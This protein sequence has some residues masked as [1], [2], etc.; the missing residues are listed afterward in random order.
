MASST[1]SSST[2]WW[3]SLGTDAKVGVGFGT[4]LILGLLGYAI[5]YW[6]TNHKSSS[7]SSMLMTPTQTTAAI[8]P[9]SGSTRTLATSK[10]TSRTSGDQARIEWELGT[11]ERLLREYQEAYPQ[12]KQDHY[13]NTFDKKYVLDALTKR[14]HRL[15]ED[16]AQL[17]GELSQPSAQLEAELSQPSAPGHMPDHE[18]KMLSVLGQYTKSSTSSYDLSVLESDRAVHDTAVQSVLAWLKG[19]GIQSIQKAKMF[20]TEALLNPN[21]TELHHE[22]AAFIDYLK[23]PLHSLHGE[24]P[25]YDLTGVSFDTFKTMS[26]ADKTR[27]ARNLWSCLLD[28]VKYC[29]PNSQLMSSHA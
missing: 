10:L 16:I 7:K 25:F 9:G 27:I 17:E 24:T 22:L 15:E 19:T 14:E 3:S 18:K 4:L 20:S 29:S 11:E 13:P 23:T 5:Y 6:W 21:P 2:S 26:S 1:S 8:S 28:D 12:L